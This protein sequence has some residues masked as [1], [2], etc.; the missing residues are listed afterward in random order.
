MKVSTDFNLNEKQWIA[1]QI[2]A[3]SFVQGHVYNQDLDEEPLC[4]LMTGP[5]GTGKIHVVRALKD[6]MAHY[7]AAT[8]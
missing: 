7:G 6:V 2:I 8:R 3:R 5:G 4:M 1:F